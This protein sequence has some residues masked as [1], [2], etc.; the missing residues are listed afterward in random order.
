MIFRK[1][2]EEGERNFFCKFWY[3]RSIIPLIILKFD[4]MDIRTPHFFLWDKRFATLTVYRN[5]EATRKRAQN[6][7]QSTKLS[8]A[9]TALCRLHYLLWPFNLRNMKRVNIPPT[10]LTANSAHQSAHYFRHRKFQKEV[11]R[12]SPKKKK[13]P[14][15]R[16]AEREWRLLF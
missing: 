9:G 3:H 10:T 12:K 11:W 1:I 4:P 14:R 13:E 15:V 6:I 8:N 7:P 16:R 5:I 2:I